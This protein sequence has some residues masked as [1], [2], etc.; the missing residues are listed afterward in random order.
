MISYTSTTVL[1]LLYRVVAFIETAAVLK[2]IDIG[3]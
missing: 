2:D 3:P 1:S